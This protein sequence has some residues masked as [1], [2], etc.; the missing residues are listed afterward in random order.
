MRNAWK[1]K[2]KVTRESVV[3]LYRVAKKAWLI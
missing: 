3:E 2:K 1:M